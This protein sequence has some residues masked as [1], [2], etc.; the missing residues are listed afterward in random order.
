MLLF[1][2]R[3]CRELRKFA[4]DFIN[5]TLTD[6]F[7]SHLSQQDT[8]PIMDLYVSDSMQDM[9][10]IDIKS[11]VAT[12]VG[13]VNEFSSLMNFDLPSLELD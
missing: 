10:D 1:A 7:F 9:L 5:F 2:G 6:I 12:V 11:E 13:G 4:G 3:Q 8:T